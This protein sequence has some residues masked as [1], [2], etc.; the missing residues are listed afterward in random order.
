[1]QFAGKGSGSPSHSTVGGSR[2]ARTAVST[3]TGDSGAAQGTQ[4]QGGSADRANES[5]VAGLFAD[6]SGMSRQSSSGGGVDGLL[7]KH[8]ANGSAT[9]EMGSVRQSPRKNM[10][11]ASTGQ[12]NAKRELAID[13]RGGELARVGPRGM[14]SSTRSDAGTHS[15]A[16]AGAG[17]EL[18]ALAA[19]RTADVSVSMRDLQAATR[20]G[21]GLNSHLG[22]RRVGGGSGPGH[23]GSSNGTGTGGTSIAGTKSVEGSAV[24]G[25]EDGAIHSARRPVPS[26]GGVTAMTPSLGSSGGDSG[27]SRMPGGVEGDVGGTHGG[28]HGVS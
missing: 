2:G 17:L 28:R 27:G 7:H 22:V 21:K 24:I 1:M 12:A 15:H 13:I 26:G 16:R 11:H 20:R 4:Q 19:S 6:M 18:D 25:P 5:A 23:T 14:P 8:E 3:P 9:R 10:G